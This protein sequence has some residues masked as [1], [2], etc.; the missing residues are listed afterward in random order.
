MVFTCDDELDLLAVLELR[1]FTS[2]DDDDELMTRMARLV[3]MD[4]QSYEVIRV[5][6]LDYIFRWVGEGG[7]KALWD[8]SQTGMRTIFYYI[9]TFTVFLLKNMLVALASV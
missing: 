3:F 4:N 9:H 8:G 1:E 6:E 2:N 5:A 7:R